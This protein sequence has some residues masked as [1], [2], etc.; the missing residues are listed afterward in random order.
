MVG[1]IPE[2]ITVPETTTLT[3]TKLAT[4]V[5]SMDILSEI[6]L[7]G[8]MRIEIFPCQTKLSPV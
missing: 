4:S 7:Y 2:A 8:M 6:V 1:V 3:P 5:E